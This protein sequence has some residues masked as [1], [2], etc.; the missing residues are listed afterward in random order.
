MT[1]TGDWGRGRDN[2][3]VS[4]YDEV[5]EEYMSTKSSLYPRGESSTA[6][7]VLILQSVQ[8]SDGGSCPGLL[9]SCTRGQHQLSDLHC[10]SVAMTRMI[11]A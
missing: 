6:W 4:T 9:Y 2:N 10:M 7:N 8:R 1:G 3:L 11:E 5:M